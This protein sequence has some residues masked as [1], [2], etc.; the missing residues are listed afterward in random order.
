MQR[1]ALESRVFYLISNQDSPF[2]H[3]HD[4]ARWPS[5]S[6]ARLFTTSCALPLPHVRHPTFPPSRLSRILHPS[7]FTPFL[8][9]TLTHDINPISSFQHPRLHHAQKRQESQEYAV[10]SKG[11][12]GEKEVK[13]VGALNKAKRR[14]GGGEADCCFLF[15][16]SGTAT[17][18]EG[19]S[20]QVG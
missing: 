8:S 14:E 5:S 9:T 18:Q 10:T 3:A 6:S 19:E 15:G 1:R 13:A 4:A 16:P 11:E 2:H 17:K 12:D 20:D 7:L